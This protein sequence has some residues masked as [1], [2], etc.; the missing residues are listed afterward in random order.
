MLVAY[1]GTGII[2]VPMA[3]EALALAYI[4]S[5]VTRQAAPA[6]LAA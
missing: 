5:K 1:L 3:F 4:L 6:T 2:P